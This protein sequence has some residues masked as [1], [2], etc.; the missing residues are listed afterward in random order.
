M[1]RFEERECL[2]H[3]SSSGSSIGKWIYLPPLWSQ[4]FRPLWFQTW[5]QLTAKFRSYSTNSLSHNKDAN[6]AVHN[7]V[8]KYRVQFPELTSREICSFSITAT[9]AKKISRRHITHRQHTRTVQ[10]QR[11]VHKRWIPGEQEQNFTNTPF[12]WPDQREL[13][14][15]SS[16]W[17]STS[18]EQHTSRSN[19]NK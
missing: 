9:D 10:Q 2:K 13:G 4:M 12:C 19:V 17:L 3:V 5:F 16:E 6:I 1:H 11:N 14:G 15:L 18:A 8:S 7:L